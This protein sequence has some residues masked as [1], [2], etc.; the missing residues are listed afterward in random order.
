MTPDGA[1]WLEGAGLGLFQGRILMDE[2]PGRISVRRASGTGASFKGSSMGVS[3][4]W[5]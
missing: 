4:C 1:I 3:L 2:R 5:A